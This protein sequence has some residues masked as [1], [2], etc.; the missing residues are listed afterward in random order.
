MGFDRYANMSMQCITS[1]SKLLEIARG[2]QGKNMKNTNFYRLKTEPQREKTGLG[3]LRP[4]PT[5][6]CQVLLNTS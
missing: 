2:V 6:I 5:Q 3:S 4:G 1:T